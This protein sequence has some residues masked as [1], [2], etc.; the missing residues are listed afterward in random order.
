MHP[1]PTLFYASRAYVVLCIPTYVVFINTNHTLVF[2]SQT[3]IV[4]CIPHPHCFMHPECWIN[5]AP[6][7]QY[8]QIIS[9]KI[10]DS[11]PPSES[12]IFSNFVRRP[13]LKSSTCCLIQQRCGYPILRSKPICYSVNSQYN[14]LN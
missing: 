9:G 11:L 1:E 12:G 10:S 14:L 8:H 3:H 2:E 5:P 13:Y 4:L 6:I 7:I